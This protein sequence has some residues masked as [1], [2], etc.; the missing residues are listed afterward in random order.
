MGTHRTADAV[1]VGATSTG[2]GLLQ[3]PS[4]LLLSQT[5]KTA[6]DG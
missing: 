2:I 6:N 4:D 5:I 3:V 1:I